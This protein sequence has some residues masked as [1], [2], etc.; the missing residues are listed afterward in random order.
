MKRERRQQATIEEREIPF[1]ELG[2]Y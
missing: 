1:S 2:I